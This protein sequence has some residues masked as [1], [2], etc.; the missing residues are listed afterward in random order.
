MGYSYLDGPSLLGLPSMVSF[1][2]SN[3][4]S[5][6]CYMRGHEVSPRRVWCLFRA[7]MIAIPDHADHDSG[8]CRSVFGVSRKGGRVL[9]EEMK[10]GTLAGIAK[11]PALMREPYEVRYLRRV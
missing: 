5:V 9:C 8:R 2:D 10:S 7:M 11:P 4:G 3:S 1:P 6:A